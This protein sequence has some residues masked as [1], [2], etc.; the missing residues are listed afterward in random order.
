MCIAVEFFK[1]GERVLVR[2]DV[3]GGDLPVR[4]RNG[5]VRLYRWGSSG[6]PRVYD[7][8]PGYLLNWPAGGWVALDVLKRGEW[9]QLK[10]APVRVAAARF[11]VFRTNGSV[12]WEDWIDLKP[13]EYLQG[14][15]AQRHGDYR[16]YVVTIDP[17]AKSQGASPWPRVVTARRRAARA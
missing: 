17:P 10:P 15:L 7:E 13:G 11:L 12:T 2:G 16:V 9:W 8:A 5:E 1:N 14:A 4:L 6:R 3:D